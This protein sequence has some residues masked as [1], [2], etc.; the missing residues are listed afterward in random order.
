[1]QPLCLRYSP[2]LHLVL[3]MEHEFKPIFGVTASTNLTL[4]HFGHRTCRGVAGPQV[5]RVANRPFAQKT[6]GGRRMN[7]LLFEG[8]GAMLV[9]S[10][11]E[12]RPFHFSISQRKHAWCSIGNPIDSQRW[13][14]PLLGL[15]SCGWICVGLFGRGW[16]VVSWSADV[17]WPRKQWGREGGPHF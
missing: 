6:P 3:D 15:P 7:Q 14:L 4:R 5:I 9:L 8:P 10:V 13:S 12:S 11:C 17:S 2:G 1:M 16:F